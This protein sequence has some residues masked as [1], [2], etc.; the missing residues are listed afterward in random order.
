MGRAWKYEKERSP[1]IVVSLEEEI[2]AGVGSQLI[3][4]GFYPL[5]GGHKCPEDLGSGPHP[6]RRRA[7]EANPNLVTAKP[8]KRRG[9]DIGKGEAQQPAFWG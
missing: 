3:A 1:T 8:L 2:F 6:T 7:L 4:L 9:M 5:Q